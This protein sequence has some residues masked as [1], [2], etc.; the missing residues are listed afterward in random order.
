MRA[1][2]IALFLFVFGCA[3]SPKAPEATKAPEVVET[4]RPRVMVAHHTAVPVT[5]DGRLDEPV[6][7]R[8][9][10]YRMSH[11]VSA[12]GDSEPVE[13]TGTVRLA[14]DDSNFYLAVDFVDRDL[15]AEGPADELHHYKLGDLAELFLKPQG[16][17]CYWELYVT[18]ASRKTTMFFPSRGHFGL[19]ST[20][21]YTS[22]LRVAAKA[23]GTVNHWQDEDEGW[24]AEM[25]MPIDDLTARGGNFG[26]G[27]PWRILVGRYNYGVHRTR[28]GPEITMTPGMSQRNFHY[29][30]EYAVLELVR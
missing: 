7:A 25:A 26:P 10:V 18:P 22:D 13:Q 14:W 9:S 3:G 6:W 19:P 11:P 2:W 15:L 5:I 24:T 27:S 4:P 12:N 28:I 29:H 17:S 16:K 30:K 23:Q 8:A 20:V 21:E 1:A